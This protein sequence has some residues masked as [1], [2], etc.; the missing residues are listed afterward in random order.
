TL[1]IRAL[2]S[3]RCGE[4]RAYPKEIFADVDILTPNQSEA[5][6]LLGL[7]ADDRQADADLAARL[8]G[9]GV[10]YVVMTLGA[11]G[12]LIAG[13]EGLTKVASYPV[14][15][16]DTTGAGD[17]FNG[18]LAAGLANGLALADAVRRG[19]AAG[20]LAVTKKLVVPALPDDSQISELMKHRT[21]CA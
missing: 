20:A 5:R 7:N 21:A 17:A 3:K 9:L 18:A 2:N 13:P 8:R 1:C 4:I 10:K 11:D 19:T 14:D 16:V 15:V 12:A 6:I